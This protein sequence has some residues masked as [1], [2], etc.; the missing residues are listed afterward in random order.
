M[1][2]EKGIE[3]LSIARSQVYAGRFQSKRCRGAVRKQEIYDQVRPGLY[4]QRRAEIC[5]VQELRDFKEPQLRAGS[6]GAA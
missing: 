2:D 1:R 4:D 6:F 5:H 3:R